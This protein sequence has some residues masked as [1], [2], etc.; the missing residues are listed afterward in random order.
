LIGLVTITTVQR[1]KEIGIRKVLGSTVLGIIGL[2]SKDYIKLILISIL[3]ATPI[4]WWTMHKWL[5]D[6]AYKIDLSWWMFIIPAVATLLI[7]F[8]TMSYQSIKAARANPVN[9]LRDE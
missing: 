5:D 3:I 4:A 1:T 6:F 2:L 9:S 7:A 8:F